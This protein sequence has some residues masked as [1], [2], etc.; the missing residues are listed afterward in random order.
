MKLN[1][2]PLWLAL[3]GL[4]CGCVSPTPLPPVVPGCDAVYA[5]L[6]GFANSERAGLVRANERWNA[7]G[8]KTYCLVDA[9]PGD[10]EH[11]IRSI[12]YGGPEWQQVSKDFGG[13][14]IL[15]L[16]I[17][18]ADNI[19][20]VD[21]MS[22]DLFELVALHEFGHARGLD[23]VDAPGIMHA[24]IGTATDFTSNDLLE[25]VRV[26]ACGTSAFVEPVELTTQP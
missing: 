23:H 4:F 22:P 24:G 7:F 2:R 20:I 16:Y 6:P 11:T 9:A 21:S 26:G 3:C 5:V 17:G 25:C 14:N 13:A 15:G 18:K 8:N 12:H 19:V 1:L 10:S